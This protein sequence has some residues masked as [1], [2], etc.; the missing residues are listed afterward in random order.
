MEV[1]GEG[2]EDRRSLKL[3]EPFRDLLRTKEIDS[4]KKIEQ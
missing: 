2:V 3:E 4:K 1:G